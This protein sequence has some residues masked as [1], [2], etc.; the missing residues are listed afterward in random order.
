MPSSKNGHPIPRGGKG[1]GRR[2]M[3]HDKP[4]THRGGCPCCYP[5]VWDAYRPRNPGLSRR[6]FFG[7][8]DAFTA[9]ALSALTGKSEAGAAGAAELATALAFTTPDNTLGENQQS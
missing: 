5:Y 1:E 2:R 6:G 7:E 8:G 3:G 9:A 4:A